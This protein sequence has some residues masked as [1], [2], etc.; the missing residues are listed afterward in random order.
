MRAVCLRLG[1]VLNQADLARDTGLARSTLQRYLNLLEVSYQLVRLEPYS[2][3]RT[4]RL[5]KSPKIYWSDSGLALYLSGEGPASGPHL[6][7]IV[8]T[9]LL[10]WRELQSMR[11]SILFWRTS[12]GE[13]VDFVVE[14]KGR[15]LGIEVKATR[16]PGLNDARGLRAFLGEYGASALGG[17]LLHGGDGVFWIADRVLAAPWW[18]VI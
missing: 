8:C 13:E 12:T 17:L 16:N 10:A 18:K 1:T 4:K 5:V 15:L 7:N 11:P 2:V 6:E 9:D 14:A 3:N